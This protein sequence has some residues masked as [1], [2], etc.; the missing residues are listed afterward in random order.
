MSFKSTFEDANSFEIAFWMMSLTPS[1]KSEDDCLF[2]NASAWSLTYEVQARLIPI[3][4]ENYVNDILTG[5]AM[6]RKLSS[7]LTTPLSWSPKRSLRELRDSR[8]MNES[9]SWR[10]SL[11][12]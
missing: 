3:V 2:Q 1:A 7:P 9:A 4:V 11:G 10:R 5:Y 8:N 12:H 6:L